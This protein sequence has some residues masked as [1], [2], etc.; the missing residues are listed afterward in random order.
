MGWF[1]SKDGVRYHGGDT[2]LASSWNAMFPD[3]V[4]VVMLTNAAM[5]RFTIG[6]GALAYEVHN[7]VAGVAPLTVPKVEHPGFNLTSCPM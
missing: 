5:S 2:Q 1:I 7:A 3:G 6:R 4:D